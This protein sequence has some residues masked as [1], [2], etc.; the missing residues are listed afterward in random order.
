MVRQDHLGFSVI[1]QLRR[2]WIGEPPDERFRPSLY[3]ANQWQI[4][5][6]DRRLS[7]K[8]TPR[9]SPLPGG[10]RRQKL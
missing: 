6:P 5:M 4:T 2:L 1:G 9:T 7:K 3:A 10:F 8:A